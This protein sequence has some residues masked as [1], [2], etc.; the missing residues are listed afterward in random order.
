ML[1]MGNLSSLHPRTLRQIC[2]RS[3]YKVFLSCGSGLSGGLQRT[4]YIF[5]PVFHLVTIQQPQ[6]QGHAHFTARSCSHIKAQML[7]LH[8]RG[9]VGETGHSC[10]V[11]HEHQ[12]GGAKCQ[13]LCTLRYQQLRHPAVRRTQ[14]IRLSPGFTGRQ[15][16]LI[17]PAAI[18]MHAASSIV[19]SRGHVGCGSLALSPLLRNKLTHRP[20]SQTPS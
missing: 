12:Q 19:Q 17:E 9:E 11:F 15:G 7:T 4:M 18:C 10:W 8:W 16:E 3:G 1:F 13:I 5:A 14:C 2:L 20:G 6:L